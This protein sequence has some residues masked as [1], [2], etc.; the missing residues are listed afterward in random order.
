VLLIEWT[1]RVCFDM[2]GCGVTNQHQRSVGKMRKGRR[3][4][5][6]RNRN[7]GDDDRNV[8][9]ELM[10]IWRG[11]IDVWSDRRQSKMLY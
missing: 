8:H 10:E 7:Y 2:R 9:V 1:K 5:G 6:C 11:E 4:E 3:T